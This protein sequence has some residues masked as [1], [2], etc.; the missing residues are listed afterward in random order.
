MDSLV[1]RFEADK[2]CDFKKK[3]SGM[4]RSKS[5][6]SME[7]WSGDRLFTKQIQNWKQSKIDFEFP[8]MVRVVTEFDRTVADSTEFADEANLFWPFP[9]V[10]LKMR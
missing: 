2:L 9:G 3:F 5:A 1:D 7:S 10:Q 6:R 8:K 4:R